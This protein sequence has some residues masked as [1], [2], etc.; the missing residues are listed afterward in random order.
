MSTSSTK[1]PDQEAQPSSNMSEEDKRE[2]SDR[3][4]GSARVVHEVVRLQGDEE[5]GRPV[6]SLLFSG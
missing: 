6:R 2:V 3:G 4:A 5:L 1:T